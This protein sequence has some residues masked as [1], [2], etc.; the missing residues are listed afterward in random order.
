VRPRSRLVR[1][2]FARRR[3]WL[4][5]ARALCFRLLL[6]HFSSG[7]GARFQSRHVAAA[8][9]DRDRAGVLDIVEKCCR[10]GQREGFRDARAGRARR[11]IRRFTFYD[12]SGSAAHSWMYGLYIDILASLRRVNPAYCNAREKIFFCCQRGK[13]IPEKRKQ[14]RARAHVTGSECLE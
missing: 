12:G 5:S 3:A 7:I 10:K 6:R 4:A 13:D 11:R 2:R 1:R 14:A 9:R 8:G